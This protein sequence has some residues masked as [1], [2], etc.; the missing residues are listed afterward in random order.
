MIT[1]YKKTKTGK[2]QEWAASAT[3]EG[4]IVTVYGQ[5]D[6]KKQRTEKQCK[7]KNVGRSNATTAEE[8][9]QKELLAL[10][11]KQRDKGYFDTLEQVRDCVVIRPMLAH[12]ADDKLHKI[13]FPCTS[14]PK[15]DGVRCLAHKTGGSVHLSSRSGKNLATLD[16]IVQDLQKLNLPDGYVWDGELYLHGASLQTINSYIKRYQQ[17]KTENIK[18]CLYD[19][20][21]PDKTEPWRVRRRA[22]EAVRSVSDIPSIDVVRNLPC[23]SQDE[24]GP[25]HAGYLS[26]GY[27]GMMLRDD[28]A[29]YLIGHRS[30]FLLKVKLFQD[31]EFEV[32]GHTNGIGRFKNCVIW[33]C[34]TQEG[35]TFDVVPKGTMEQRAMYLD[36]APK[37]YGRKLTVQFFDKTDD[38]KPRF[39][40]GIAF[41]EDYD[42]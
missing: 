28:A 4:T 22:V 31:E 5:K 3:P 1:L 10:A 20:F 42:Q 2:I 33:K 39:P 13:N 32:I 23:A 35:K 11:E 19:R 6:G 30:E 18:Y 12:K 37:Y 34:K 29:P 36:M 40:V 24:I 17:G 16:H 41:R 14:Q 9:A 25:L 15:L 21:H 27:E 26:Q 8:Q 7:P 38:N